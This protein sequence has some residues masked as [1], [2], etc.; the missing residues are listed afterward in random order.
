MDMKPYNWLREAQIYNK[1]NTKISLEWLTE[2]ADVIALLFTSNGVDKDGVVEK[3]YTIY[4]NV[5]FINM[6]IEVIY[7]P[8]DENE[9][10]MLSC[11]EGQANWFTLKINDPLIN[12]LKHMYGITCMPYIVVI[13][14]NGTIV[15]TT[16]IQDLEEYGKNALITWLSMS[17]PVTKERKLSRE[18]SVYGDKW[19][20]VGSDEAK[21]RQ[22]YHRRFSVVEESS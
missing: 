3:F 15:S 16:G 1:K 8:M 21:K 7:V 12:V 5:K 20:Y 6:A 22:E 19:M 9:E 10:D 4:E 14:P 2:N 13:K 18:A 17:K 11:Y